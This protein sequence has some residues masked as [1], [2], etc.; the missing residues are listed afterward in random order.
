[1]AEVPKLDHEQQILELKSAGWEQKS[2]NIW[3]DPDG[4]LYATVM[5]SWKVMNQ[6][7]AEK[8]SIEGG[9]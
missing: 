1:M 4:R 9:K 8:A 7:K 2:K 5:F 6:R 3:A